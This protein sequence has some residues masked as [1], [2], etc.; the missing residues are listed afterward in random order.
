MAGYSPYCTEPS[1]S[2]KSGEFL[3]QLSDYYFCK[4]TLV[5]GV[6]LGSTPTKLWFLPL[7]GTK[8]GCPACVGGLRPT[9]FVRI[10]WSLGSVSIHCALDGDRR[11]LLITIA[12]G[13][14][15]APPHGSSLSPLTIPFHRAVIYLSG[16]YHEKA[17]KSE[18]GGIDHKMRTGVRRVEGERCRKYTR[19]G[20]VARSCGSPTC[21]LI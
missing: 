17:S 12:S 9:H 21:S 14:P 20:K 4:R 6:S 10:G 3:D 19:K 18:G 11:R 7:L 13:Q 5:D 16:D 2:I 8:P 15:T 1:G